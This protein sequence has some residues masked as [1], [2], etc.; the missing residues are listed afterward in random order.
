MPFKSRHFSHE[1][2][3]RVAQ[4][5]EHDIASNSQSE[6]NRLLAAGWLTDCVSNHER[7]NYDSTQ[8]LPKRLLDLSSGVDNAKYIRLVETDN[9]SSNV[10]YMTLSHCWGSK[11]VIRL[12]RHTLEGLISGLSIS[13]L[14]Q[15]FQDAIV[16]AGWFG[17]QYLWIDSLCIMQDMIEDWERESAQM[18]H[19][20]RNARLNIAATG[21]TDSHSGLFH[22]RDPSMV[23]SGLLKTAWNGQLPKGTFRFFWRQIWDHGVNKAP[24]CRRA[25]VVQERCL[26]RR[27]V[28]FGS[29]SIY[30]E[31]HEL[32]ACEAFPAGLPQAFRGLVRNRLKAGALPTFRGSSSEATSSF[33]SWQKIV[34]AYMQ[35][36]LTYASDKVIALSGVAADFAKSSNGIY[37][38]G[39]WKN[40]YFI[41][42]LL[43]TVRD[44]YRQLNGQPSVRPSKY[45]APSWSWMS[46][47]ANI[48]LPL[49]F[50]PALIEVLDT[51]VELVNDS[52][53]FG[54]LKA[55]FISICG[56][57]ISTRLRKKPDT[58]AEYYAVDPSGVQAGCVRLAFDTTDD[59]A[60]EAFCMPVRFSW[61]G[62]LEGLLLQLSGNEDMMFRRVG[63]F[64]TDDTQLQETWV[65]KG[66]DQNVVLKIV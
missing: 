13:N 57:L 48:T 12:T 6:S 50:E 66:G 60:T 63:H 49:I 41:S 31:C 2:G 55:G 3:T 43:W 27:N 16:V 29:E 62:H 53:P 33:R 4:T 34:I 22:D 30:F 11:P 17:S 15:T 44:G 51:K 18:Y 61:K 26:A 9:S 5:I 65:P 47:D 8:H 36:S 14:P 28:H 42:Q 20:Y 45:R 32:E 56:Y 21:A 23:S 10:E 1:S 40:D 37:L 59:F 38:A 25:W 7:C 52:I 58:R 64:K 46:I 54:A 24:L 35:C 39:L 19:I